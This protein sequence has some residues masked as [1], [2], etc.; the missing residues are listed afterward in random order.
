MVSEPWLVAL[1]GFHDFFEAV[2]FGPQGFGRVKC[3]VVVP[4]HLSGCTNGRVVVHEFLSQWHKGV[5]SLT[6]SEVF[7]S[8]SSVDSGWEV[9]GV[10]Q[11]IA[12]V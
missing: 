12:M 4:G 8:P 3:S 5:K 6:S 10:D 2:E 7:W 1:E 11:G 9:G